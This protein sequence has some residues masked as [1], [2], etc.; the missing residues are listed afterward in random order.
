[1]QL[2]YTCVKSVSPTNPG[3]PLPSCFMQTYL[4]IHSSGFG[5]ASSLSSFWYKASSLH[6]L[7][8]SGR[9]EQCS[10]RVRVYGS[11]GTDNKTSV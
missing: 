10:A 11:V 1:M 6:A 4:P 7:E 5:V 8:H 2:T 3:Y 9:T